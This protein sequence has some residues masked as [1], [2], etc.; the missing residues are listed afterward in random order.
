MFVEYMRGG[1]CGCTGM[2][3]VYGWKT[4][5]ICS[6]G[7]VYHAEGCAEGQGEFGCEI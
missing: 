4:W 2:I 5:R 3:G 6:G 1:I 7:I